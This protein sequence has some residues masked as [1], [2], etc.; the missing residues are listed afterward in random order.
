[1]LDHGFNNR[2]KYIKQ[3]KGKN[4]PDYVKDIT[5]KNEKRSCNDKCWKCGWNFGPIEFIS[6]KFDNHQLNWH[7]NLCCA[8]IASLFASTVYTDHK[9]LESLFD[10]RSKQ[11][12][13]ILSRWSLQLSEFSFEARYFSGTE[14]VVA[15][16]LSRNPDAIPKTEQ[17]LV[18]TRT[19]IQQNINQE[20]KFSNEDLKNQI[21][22]S[23]EL[24]REI[25]DFDQIFKTETFVEAQES[26]NVLK[27][28]KENLLKQISE[29]MNLPLHW[30]TAWYKGELVVDRVNLL[31]RAGKVVVPDQMKCL[32]TFIL[33]Y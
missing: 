7:I 6:K 28:I 11:V 27:Y 17:I 12:N 1:V 2:N 8:K 24:S 23:F 26:D 25:R 10:V 16:F 22:K 18:F 30:H 29:A 33:T 15:D 9:N 4:I 13:S 21:E 32:I 19:Q 31:L 20:N 3:Y 5:R 14:N